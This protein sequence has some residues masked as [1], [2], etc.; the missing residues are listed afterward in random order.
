MF[1]GHVNH[2]F[3]QYLHFLNRES[4]QD[5]TYTES[6]VIC[7]FWLIVFQN[8]LNFLFGQDVFLILVI[9]VFIRFFLLLQFFPSVC[10]LS[11]DLLCDSCVCSLFFSSLFLVPLLIYLSQAATLTCSQSPISSAVSHTS[12]PR[13]YIFTVQFFVIGSVPQ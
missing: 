5:P 2:L 1:W 13:L 4:T 3:S 10:V 6:I 7:V 9:L 12:L 11:L 8:S